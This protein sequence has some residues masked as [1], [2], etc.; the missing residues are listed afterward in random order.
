MLESLHP[1]GSVLFF[2]FRCFFGVPKL[3]DL[4]FFL[5]VLVFLVSAVFFSVEIWS[6]N[7]GI[8]NHYNRGCLHIVHDVQSSAYFLVL[9]SPWFLCENM[10]E[11]V[12]KDGNGTSP[13]TSIN[14]GLI[15]KLTDKW[16]IFQPAM[17]DSRRV[18]TLPGAIR[19]LR[20]RPGQR[21]AS[22]KCRGLKGVEVSG[23]TIHM[24]CI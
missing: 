7:N 22:R 20:R 23:Y 18:S 1:D 9:Y 2:F 15:R 24:E 5:L 10:I 17:L 19:R 3:Q 21:K 8:T 12:I 13:I 16:S 6:Q 14:G 11:L 4:C